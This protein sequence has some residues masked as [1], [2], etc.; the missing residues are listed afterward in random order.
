MNSTLENLPRD[1]NGKISKDYLRV[2]LVVSPSAGLLPV[3]AIQE[4]REGGSHCNTKGTIRAMKIRVVF[5]N[6]R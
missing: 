2:A 3:G 5:S 6:W 1:R 4:Y